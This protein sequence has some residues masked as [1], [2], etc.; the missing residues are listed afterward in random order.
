MVHGGRR[1]QQCSAEFA[2]DAAA[3]SYQGVLGDNAAGLV[4]EGPFIHAFMWQIVVLLVSAGV[5]QLWACQVDQF[6]P[7]AAARDRCRIADAR[8]AERISGW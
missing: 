3:R 4:G 2:H 6:G 7:K 8:T 5:A 1:G